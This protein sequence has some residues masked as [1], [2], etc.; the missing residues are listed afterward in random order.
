L[1]TQLQIDILSTAHNSVVAAVGPELVNRS[2]RWRI[3][4][5]PIERPF[6]GYGYGNYFINDSFVSSNNYLDYF[7]I[8]GVLGTNEGFGIIESQNDGDLPDYLE[9]L[10]YSYSFGYE[11]GSFIK[12]DDDDTIIIKATVYEN[13][14]EQP[15]IRVVFKGSPGIVI[16]PTTDVTDAFGSVYVEV[17]LYYTTVQNTARSPF[18]NVSSIISHNGVITISAEIDQ[19]PHEDEGFLVIRT[20]SVQLTE[21]TIN[22]FDISTY[23]FQ[24]SYGYASTLSY[25]YDPF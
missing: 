3:D 25:G 2:E 15:D 17:S 13:D 6:Y 22:I 9:D 16:T 19:N 23:S 4:L 12:A 10:D 20:Q 21:T 14:V 18:G 5:E 8:I 1:P 7:N 11:Y 24:D